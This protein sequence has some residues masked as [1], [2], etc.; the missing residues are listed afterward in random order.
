MVEP[1]TQTWPSAV[2]LSRTINTMVP[3]NSEDHS[4]EHG[5]S[6]GMALGHQ[7]GHRKQPRPQTSVWP[8]V[9][10]Q[11]P[12]ITNPNCGRIMDPNMMLGSSPGSDVTMTPGRSTGYSDQ[13]GPPNRVA[14]GHKHVPSGG[15]YP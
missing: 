15:P 7:H 13:D 8:L 4:D 5:P 3:G 6:S 14:L 2:A 10:P 11:A 1:Q 12:D 9:A